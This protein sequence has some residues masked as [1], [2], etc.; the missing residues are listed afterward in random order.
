MTRGDAD[1]ALV[2]FSRADRPTAWRVVRIVGTY[3][4]SML[5]VAELTRSSRRYVVT[6]DQI[7]E[8]G[9]PSTCFL[10]RNRYRLAMLPELDEEAL[11]ETAVARVR[12]EHEQVLE[13]RIRARHACEAKLAALRA[14]PA[15]AGMGPKIPTQGDPSSTSEEREGE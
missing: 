10:T 3:R 12:G 9:A 2:A 7:V 1:C 8:R 5:V 11:A 13:R 15:A 4:G 14:M 6:S